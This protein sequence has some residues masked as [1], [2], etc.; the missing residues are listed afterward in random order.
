MWLNKLA[1]SKMITHSKGSQAAA[2]AETCHQQVDRSPEN[3]SLPTGYGF[4]GPR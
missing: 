4:T 3:P 1:M 2:E